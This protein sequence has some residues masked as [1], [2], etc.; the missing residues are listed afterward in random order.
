MSV[1]SS[2]YNTM[3]N[4][5]WESNV[6]LILHIKID[7]SSTFP[8]VWILFLCE[9]NLLCAACTVK[10]HTHLP[11]RLQLWCGFGSSPIM[12]LQLWGQM[13]HFS[14]EA[15]T[16]QIKLTT[17]LSFPCSSKLSSFNMLVRSAKNA[18]SSSHWL[19]WSCL[20]SACSGQSSRNL[21]RNL[22]H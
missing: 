7:I 18:K 10:L 22:P 12:V 3:H 8:H 5:Y 9:L 21:S 19:S 11:L 6:T 2:L 17:V 15:L 14:F 13:F 16:E 4:W 1:T 20:C